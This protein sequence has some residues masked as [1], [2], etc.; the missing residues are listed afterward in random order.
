[1]ASTRLLGGR[2]VSECGHPNPCKSFKTDCGAGGT[3]VID[4][5]SQENSP[6]CYCAKG[7]LYSGSA[8]LPGPDVC[9]KGNYKCYNGGTCVYDGKRVHC[10]CKQRFGGKQCELKGEDKCLKGKQIHKCVKDD[11]CHYSLKTGRLWCKCP[12]RR[13]GSTCS[14]GNQ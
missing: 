4:Y 5:P 8:C 3:C 9:R 11:Y 7:F 12:I 13:A 6:Y 2:S 14:K 1:M 10:R